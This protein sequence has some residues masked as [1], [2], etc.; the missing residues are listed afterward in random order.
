MELFFCP[1]ISDEAA[2]VTLDDFESRHITRTLRK[3]KGDV[4]ELTDGAGYQYTGTI[5]TLKPSVTVKINSK[6][7]HE[8]PR[9]A[10]HAAMGF[11]KH[12]RLEWALEKATELG[13]TD[14]H[15]IRTEYS[16]YG[17]WNHK[18]FEK[19]LRQAVK[20]NRRFYLPALHLYENLKEFTEATQTINFRFAA[21]D[22]S[23]APLREKIKNT[24]DQLL[25]TG[26]E[27]GFS[28]EEIS[29]LSETGFTGISLGPTRLRAETALIAGL[30][31]LRFMQDQP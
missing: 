5:G 13:A 28:P 1:P 26:P 12:Q 9:S 31:F 11:I 23:A 15:L 7:K 29:L 21:I 17:S 30:A 14:I 19:I 16:G 27:G 22:A 6:K 3:K 4:V 18:R 2:Y 24:G 25:L 10:L 20:Q 8:P